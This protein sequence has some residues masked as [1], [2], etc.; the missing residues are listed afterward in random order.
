MGSGVWDDDAD[1]EINFAIIRPGNCWAFSR[2]GTVVKRPDNNFVLHM[3]NGI[4][5]TISNVH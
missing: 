4:V 3:M 2:I 5:M 1:G